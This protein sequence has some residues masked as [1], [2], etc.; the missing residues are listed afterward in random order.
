ML[1]HTLGR[2][3]GILVKVKNE[4]RMSTPSPFL[5]ESNVFKYLIKYTN[6]AEF[7]EP[8]LP[9]SIGQYEIFKLPLFGQIHLLVYK[10]AN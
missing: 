7:S 4:L 10:I 3:D 1:R 2:H 8:R 6:E 9:S 5:Q